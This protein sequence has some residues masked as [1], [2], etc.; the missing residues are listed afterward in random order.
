MSKFYLLVETYVADPAVQSLL[1]KW[2]ED[3]IDLSQTDYNKL[4]EWSVDNDSIRYMLLDY[5]EP[6]M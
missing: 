2:Y 1:K 3:K 4:I 6:L 5:Y